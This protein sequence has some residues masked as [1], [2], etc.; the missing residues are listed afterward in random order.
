M[1]KEFKVR[2]P[3]LN[4]FRPIWPSIFPSGEID[5]KD[6]DWPPKSFKIQI[7]QYKYTIATTNAM[8]AMANNVGIP[9]P[10]I[11]GKVNK[12]KK[13]QVTAYERFSNGDEQN[14]VWPLLGFVV[15]IFFLYKHLK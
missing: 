12:L 5:I 15:L 1:E 9:N 2:S 6:L 10:P 14:F 4:T 3:I 13:T 8:L 11:D 7:P